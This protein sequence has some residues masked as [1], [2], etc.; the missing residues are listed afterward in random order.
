MSSG[1]TGSRE[2]SGALIANEIGPLTIGG[3]A[4]H[5]QTD[6]EIT[7]Y[8]THHHQGNNVQVLVENYTDTNYCKQSPQLVD[9]GAVTRGK[10]SGFVAT[11]RMDGTY[12]GYKRERCRK[13]GKCRHLLQH[14]QRWQIA[15]EQ[16]EV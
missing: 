9:M 10:V 11:T 13:R 15:V 14:R 5:D 6:L 8:L 3:M 4:R 7:W 16:E 12:F 2:S 1:G